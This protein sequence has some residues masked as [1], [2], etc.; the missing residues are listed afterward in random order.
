MNVTK[1]VARNANQSERPKKG[2]GSS[3]KA[4]A[5]P[6]MGSVFL[7][8]QILSLDVLL[9]PFVLGCC[10]LSTS[11]GQP[12]EWALPV[13]FFSSLYCLYSLKTDI[14]VERG[15]MKSHFPMSTQTYS[16]RYV[17]QPKPNADPPWYVIKASVHAN[18]AM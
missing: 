18:T 9:R 8:R 2:R 13:F 16:N 14:S 1:L 4:A 7:S 12:G 11:R 5:V 15:I 10:P 3:G 17:N 6:T